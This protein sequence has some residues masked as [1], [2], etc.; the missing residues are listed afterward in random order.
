M[1]DA[2]GYAEHSLSMIKAIKRIGASL[3]ASV[4]L[5]IGFGLTFLLFLGT[6]K[7]EDNAF[8][9]DF[10]QRSASQIYILQRGME[11]A[12]Q[13]LT[14]INRLFLTVEAPTRGQFHTFTTPLLQ[15]FSFVKAFSFQRIISHAERPGYEAMMQKQVPGFQISVLQQGRLMPAAEHARYL[16]VDYLEPLQ[17]NQPALGLDLSGNSEIM[18]TLARAIELNQPVSS[19]GVRLAQASANDLGVLV[20]MPVY[21]S[22]MPRDTVAQRRA[23][24]IGDTAEVFHVRTLLERIFSQASVPGAKTDR[25]SV[26]VGDSAQPEM[27]AYRSPESVTK[28]MAGRLAPLYRSPAIFNRTF[29]I[30]GQPWHVEIS[31]VR[32]ILSNHSNSLLILIA[33]SLLTLLATAYLNTLLMRSRRVQRT[34]DE[35]TAELRLT[36]ALLK[37]DIQARQLAE[38]ALQLRQRAIDASVNAII[39][40]QAKGPDYPIEYVNPAFER[41]TGYA[42]AEASGQSIRLLESAQRET[43]SFDD[44]WRIMDQRTEGNVLLRTQTKNGAPMWNDCFIA[45]VKD[46]LGETTHFVAV[47][48]DITAMKR[49]EEELAFQ[50]NCDVLTGLVNRNML[51][52][53]LNQ[54][55]AYAERY[56]HALWVVF[57]DLDRFKFVNDTLG[58]RAGD[59]LLKAVADRLRHVVR[60]AD[61]VARQGSDEFVI[62]M[63]EYPGADLDTHILHNIQ[64]AV[65][66]PLTVDGHTFFP[67]CSMGVATY[68]GD[69]KDAETLVKYADIA[70]Y[71][72]K[73][74]GRDNFQFYTPAM[75]EQALERLRIEGDLRRALE[76]EEF[77]LHYQPK[78]DLRSGKVVGMEALIRWRHPQMGM[79]A[80]ARFI[81]LAEETGLI[82]PIGAWVIRTACA[83]TKAW[84]DAGW[85]SLRVAVNLS[86]RQFLQADLVSSI[87]T[88][89]VET[90]LPPHCLELELTETLVMTDVEQ[91]IGILRQ[92]KELGVHISIDDFGTGYSSLSYLKRFPIDALKIDQSFVR[93]IS[94]DADDAAITVSII[95]LAHSLKLQVIAEGVETQEQLSFLRHHGCDE[96]Q[97]YLFSPPVS[98]EQFVQLLQETISTP[99]EGLT[100][101][102]R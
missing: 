63:S 22:G 10:E 102:A 41:I 39:I 25:I 92:F 18:A 56:Q 55:M 7:L 36:N 4:T 43:S 97:G 17:G 77:M 96:I 1:M 26:Y 21:R 30:A 65:A 42:A 61:T 57:I 24:V 28:S 12:V 69:S 75:N 9:R 11:E 89:L 47:L 8:D 14:S 16:V 45:P 68:P 100:I 64:T 52:T 23:A 27:L 33:G 58:H 83:Q 88:A 50:A 95:S 78:L 90:G 62:V 2:I 44:I 54:A 31:A 74:H 53:A 38:R 34:V 15:K 46:E 49:Y 51:R 3:S 86:I 37:A 60:S 80:P 91:A 101:S 84:H 67:T 13:V 76:R 99:A 59:L 81:G 73:L 48:H 79:V 6:S 85:E 32:P 40:M 66:A 19:G 98:A 94:V 71:R 93:D 87:A 5:C 82:L 70:M 29:V 72:A 20:L 35:R